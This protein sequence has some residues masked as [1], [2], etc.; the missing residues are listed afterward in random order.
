MAGVVLGSMNQERSRI[1]E[2]HCGGG[3]PLRSYQ[4]SMPGPPNYVHS[5]ELY[6][7]QSGDPK[8]PC[9]NL[10]CLPCN[11]PEATS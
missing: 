11:H 4:A 8:I 6:V 3:L 2:P 1:P 9:A 7:P 10:Y 5:D